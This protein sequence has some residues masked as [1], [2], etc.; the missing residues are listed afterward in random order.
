M[1]HEKYKP[2]LLFG[3]GYMTLKFSKPCATPAQISKKQVHTAHGSEFGGEHLK[4]SKS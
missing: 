3:D 4:V 1:F 2:E